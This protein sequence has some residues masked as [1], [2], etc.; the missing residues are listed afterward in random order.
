MSL[1]SYTIPKL[2][3]VVAKASS[4]TAPLYPMV[5]YHKGE[6]SSSASR[7][8][9]RC[10]PSPT[11]HRENHMQKDRRLRC[12][13]CR[14]KTKD[15]LE[16]AVHKAKHHGHPRPTR[17]STTRTQRDPRTRPGAISQIEKPLTPGRWWP[18]TQTDAAAPV[19]SLFPDDTELLDTT[20][21][22]T[23]EMAPASL[24]TIPQADVH[25]N[26]RSSPAPPN[27]TPS[28]EGIGLQSNTYRAETVEDN[29]LVIME[30]VEDRQ[31]ETD[32]SEDCVILYCHQATQTMPTEEP[33]APEASNGQT[34]EEELIQLLAKQL[35]KT[36]TGRPCC[37][38][39]KC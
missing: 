19:I 2:P 20:S 12:G 1:K 25:E 6:R 3:S 24:S 28:L 22:D 37:Q 15:T 7:R 11:H 33:P 30:T 26:P 13:E 29:R 5:S 10:L 17:S 14:Y 35:L 27:S 8:H 9:T 39:H 4:T 16:L 38:C 31:E 23:E 32:D 21:A 34:K 18:Q 36:W